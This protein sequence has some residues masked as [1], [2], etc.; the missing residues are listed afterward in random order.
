MVREL[1]NQLLFDDE[2]EGDTLEELPPPITLGTS[3]KN[4]PASSSS[5]KPRKVLQTLHRYDLL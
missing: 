1:G 4:K 5:K 2:D 3:G